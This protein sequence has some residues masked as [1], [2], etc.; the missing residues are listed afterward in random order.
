[1]SPDSGRANRRILIVDDS[2]SI[3]EDFR[4]ILCADPNG[5][6]SMD[7]LEETLFGT[8]PVLRQAFELDSAYQGQEA[9]A[10]VNQALAADAPYA[11]VFIDMR[12][13]PGWDGLQTIEQLWNVDPHLQIALC[14]AYS[15]YSFEAIE[16]RLKYNDQLLILK[17]PFDHLEIRQMASALT[18]KWQLAQDVALKVIGL[19]RTIEERVQ[20][21]LKVSHLLQYD[22]L[23]EL[24]NSTLLGDRLTQ[25]IALGRRHDTQLAVIFIGL[26]RFKRINNAL[27]YP[28]GDEVLKHVSQSLV[29]AVRESDSVFRYGSDE[30]VIVLNDIQHPR[31]TQHV[32]QKLLKA[33]NITRHIASHDLSV[34]ASLGIS[35]YPNDSGTAVE[36]I[37]HAETAMHASKEHGPDDFRFYTEDMNLRA[38]H[39]QDLESAMHQALER[40]EFVLHYQPKLDLTSGRIVGAEALLRW[41]QPQSGWIGPADFIPVAEDS[42]L[43]IPLTQWVL[44]QACTQAQAWRSMG[45]FPLCISVNISALDFRQRDFVANLAAILEQTGLPPAQLELEITESVLMQNVDDTVE[46]LQKIKAMGVRLALDDFGTGYCSLSYLRRF[47]IDVLKIDQSFVHGLTVNSRDKQLIS[48][49]IA[50]GKSLELNIIAEG[51]E[52]IEQLNVLKAL[53]CEEGQGYLFSQALPAKDFAQLLRVGCDSLMPRQ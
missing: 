34:T 4:K 19:E 21:L 15:D 51:V 49:I 28:V 6:P 50:L 17:K 39:Q 9:L 5:E 23:T 46:T 18:W 27:G 52:T 8:A 20:E 41:F 3:H 40:D 37:K 29:A 43:I 1:M 12:M 31:Q 30:F 33:I 53:Q 32:A 35:I 38:R 42:G 2:A 14:T 48:A 26:D 7:S 16:A 47:P 25:A 22:A 10:L 45:Q 36:L 44:R 24:P 11:M 13:P